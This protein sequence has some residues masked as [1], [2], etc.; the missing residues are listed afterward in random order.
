MNQSTGI[1]IAPFAVGIMCF[2]LPFLQVSCSGEK[3]IQ[4]TGVQLVTGSEMKDPMTGKETKQIPSEPL[5]V[6][7]LVALA[8]GILFC[9]SPKGASSS[10]AAIAGGIALVAMLVLKTRMD[11]QITKEAGGMPFTIDYLIG[12]WGVCLAAIAGLVLSIMRV[13][14][15]K[16]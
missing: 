15:K 3:V 12:F 14:E 2:V 10:A 8:A 16:S 11:A 9:L 13:N 4:F 5:A 1:R 7:A 6:V